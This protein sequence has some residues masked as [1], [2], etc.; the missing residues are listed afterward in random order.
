MPHTTHFAP[1]K[2][3]FPSFTVKITHAHIHI[4]EGNG[5]YTVCEWYGYA[6]FRKCRPMSSHRKSLIQHPSSPGV[7]HHKYETAVSL[8]L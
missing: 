2:A 7:T 1:S 4:H 3:S 8:K 5:K 6:M